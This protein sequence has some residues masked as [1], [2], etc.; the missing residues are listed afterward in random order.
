MVADVSIHEPRAPADDDSA[1]T[2]SMEGSNQSAPDSMRAYSWSPGWNSNQ[3]INKFQ[4]EI[5]GHLKAG[6]PGV[7]LFSGNEETN[8]EPIDL[9][10]HTPDDTSRENK[11]IIVPLWHIFGSEELSN[12]SAEISSLA[13]Q[14]Y[15]LLNQNTALQLEIQTGDGLMLANAQAVSL[16]VLIDEAIP[17]DCVVCPVLESTRAYFQSTGDYGSPIKD[18]AWIPASKS[19]DIIMSDRRS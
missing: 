14:P 6:D 4:D 1:L 16:E 18:Q 19:D 2:Y 7:K 13:P 11:I 17:D 9:T 3:S 5:A 12:N 15:A 8:G 10:T